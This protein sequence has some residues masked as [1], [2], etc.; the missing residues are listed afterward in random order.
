MSDVKRL[1][2]QD[3]QHT[4]KHGRAGS[5]RLFTITWKSRRE[6]PNWL[7]RCDLPG[8]AGH[9]WKDDNMVVLQVQAERIL[10]KWL[11]QVGQP[12]PAKPEEV[13]GS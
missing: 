12:A 5:L 9:E 1:T 4:T 13:P 3:A 11:V 2:W 7:M 10:D 8:H 6:E